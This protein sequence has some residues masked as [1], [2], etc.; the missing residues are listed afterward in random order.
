[1]QAIE[2]YLTK[3]LTFYPLAAQAL[4]NDSECVHQLRVNS[5]KLAVAIKLFAPCFSWRRRARLLKA[6]KR[7]RDAAGRVRDW[8]VFIST[9]TPWQGSVGDKY[10]IACAYLYGFCNGS[11]AAAQADL[12][13]LYTVVT[14]EDLKHLWSRA[15]DSFRIP[16]DLSGVSI[17]E[18]ARTELLS[19]YQDFVDS[20]Q[21]ESGSPQELHQSRIYAKRLRY[22]LEMLGNYSGD[23][24]VGTLG[25]DVEAAQDILGIVHDS[26][27]AILRLDKIME[28]LQKSHSITWERVRN[29]LEGFRS[30][31]EQ[32]CLRKTDE[33]QR[34][35]THWLQANIT[36][37]FS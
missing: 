22:A 9:V 3:V 8:D 30:H 32:I 33:Y 17:T 23:A 27:V 10:D 21:D 13:S 6:I 31:H 34:S 26:H 37:I 14:P 25:K 1:M 29:G 4:P 35:R 12:S 11:R 16:G 7:I 36:T 28:A 20:L 5:R 15:R 24:R 18:F 2:R 19:R